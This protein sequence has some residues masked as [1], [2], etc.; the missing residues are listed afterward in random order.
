MESLNQE[1]LDQESLETKVLGS[2]FR[3]GALA[4]LFAAV[5]YLCSACGGGSGSTNASASPA[6]AANIF[7]QKTRKK[8]EPAY[9]CLFSKFKTLQVTDLDQGIDGTTIADEYAQCSAAGRTAL[10]IYLLN[11]SANGLNSFEKQ[12]SES[13]QPY[14]IGVD[15][16]KSVSDA[17]DAYYANMNG[18]SVL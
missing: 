5:V 15:I 14:V 18:F 2:K 7:E 17:I 1:S 16:G 8:F 9:G 6:S 13:S 4:M 11:R 12:I 3:K 10:D